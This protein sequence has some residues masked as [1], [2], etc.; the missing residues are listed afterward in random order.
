[1]RVAALAERLVLEVVEDRRSTGPSAPLQP[2]PG[3]EAA[4]PVLE[5]ARDGPR[6][7]LGSV[8]VAHGP[9]VKLERV[10]RRVE[11]DVAEVRDQ[12]Y[13]WRAEEEVW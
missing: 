7:P 9:G 12:G 4:E 11:G 3:P 2:Q 13:G 1:M 6:V 5:P 10:A 8:A